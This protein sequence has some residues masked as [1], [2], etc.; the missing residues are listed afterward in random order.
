M[1]R[2]RSLL[3]QALGALK[4]LLC[5]LSP[6]PVFSYPPLFLPYGPHGTVECARP[7]ALLLLDFFVFVFYGKESLWVCAAVSRHTI[8]H[9]SLSP[10]PQYPNSA[11]PTCC[12]LRGRAEE[13]DQ[14]V[15]AGGSNKALERVLLT[16]LRAASPP[17][18][19]KIPFSQ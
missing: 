8:T 6:G 5:P 14:E 13:T 9:Q 18:V 15:T 17:T 3:Q 12:E 4:R 10:S 1:V 11:A 19:G 16:P 2:I 7:T